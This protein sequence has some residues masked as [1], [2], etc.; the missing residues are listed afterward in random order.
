V[1]TYDILFEVLEKIIHLT[2]VDG[3]NANLRNHIVFLLLID[4]P[5]FS[6][7]TLDTIQ[8]SR[9]QSNESIRTG[10]VEG[11]EEESDGRLSSFG[12]G[13]IVPG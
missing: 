8:V 9:R 4:V 1:Q 3:V 11:D 13:Q 10:H 2:F 6:G 5:A 7:L 12:L